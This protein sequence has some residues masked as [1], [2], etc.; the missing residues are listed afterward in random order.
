MRPRINLNKV[1]FREQPIGSGA[2]GKYSIQNA[3][4]FL[5]IEVTQDTLDL[6][7]EASKEYTA[8]FGID[9]YQVKAALAGLKLNPKIHA[10]TDEVKAKKIIDKILQKS[11]II[12]SAEDGH[13]WITIGRKSGYYYQVVDA[14]RKPLLNKRTW[15]QIVDIVGNEKDFYFIQVTR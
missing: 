11:P 6:L 2:C 4:L 7:T 5:G 9:Q 13:H 8:R 1:K 3:L 15:K 10:Y 12:L 14:A